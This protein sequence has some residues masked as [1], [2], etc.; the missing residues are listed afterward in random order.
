MADG[1][2]RIISIGARSHELL[3]GGNDSPHW[4]HVHQAS[5]GQ[6]RVWIPAS[7]ATIVEDGI[8]L[9][10]LHVVQVESVISAATKFGFPM[11]DEHLMLAQVDEQIRR[12]MAAACRSATNSGGA[13]IIYDNRCWGVEQVSIVESFTAA[14][15]VAEIVY[16]RVDDPWGQLIRGSLNWPGGG[17]APA[18]RG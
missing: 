11:A 5:E 10:M 17:E 13:I 6:G 4:Q 9:W 14:I 8:L 7:E 3:L 2:M 12:E 18:R 16:E 1:I 15:A